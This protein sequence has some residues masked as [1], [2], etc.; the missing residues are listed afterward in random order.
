MHTPAAFR[1][2][3][4]FTRTTI[5]IP[6]IDNLI[7]ISKHRLLEMEQ[8]EVEDP[9]NNNNKSISTNGLF[10]NDWGQSGFKLGGG[11]WPLK[12]PSYW[13]SSVSFLLQFVF[14][15]FFFY[16]CWFYQFYATK[17]YFKQFEDTYLP[18]NCAILRGQHQYF[19]L[20]HIV[21]V[22]SELSEDSPRTVWA[23]LVKSKQSPSCPR[24]VLGQSE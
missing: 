21:W 9:D 15:F 13:L 22:D 7:D 12:T 5:P 3:P 23:V 14:F 8:S 18:K 6:S 1:V 19:T 10:V 24:T 20:P 2:I 11:G 16:S 17:R 4:Y